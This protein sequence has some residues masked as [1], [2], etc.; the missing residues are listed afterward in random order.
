MLIP[1][2]GVF[3]SENYHPKGWLV[4]RYDSEGLIAEQRW[5]SPSQVEEARTYVTHLKGKAKS[6]QQIVAEEYALGREHL[7]WLVQDTGLNDNRWLTLDII[8]FQRDAAKL[9]AA[10]RHSR[11]GADD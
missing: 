10:E 9:S 2:D 5:F 7:F 6:L 1:T 11:L 4:G 3:M 8:R